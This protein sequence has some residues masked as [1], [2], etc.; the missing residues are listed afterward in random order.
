M[1]VLNQGDLLM[2]QQMQQ[3]LFTPSDDIM[4][5]RERE[6]AQRIRDNSDTFT[7]R[8]MASIHKMS[9]PFLRDFAQ[10]YGITFADGSR[11]KRLSSATIRREK[12]HTSTVVA[13]SVSR[14]PVTSLD[15]DK[16]TPDLLERARRRDQESVNG[17]IERLRE[18]A[19][20]H[21]REQAAKLVG[22][23]PTFMRR[24]AYDQELVFVGEST[25]AGRAN[26]PSAMRKL[27]GSLFRPGIK[28]KPSSALMMR[29]FVISDVAD[30]L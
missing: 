23:S 10:R 12:Q 4:A 24:L 25:N 30:V 29:H 27:Q 21:T 8:Q 15:A 14:K 28:V 9:I 17:F 2:Q 1:C 22:I 6:V 19:A 3:A 7:I 13:R 26:T 18:L 5:I 11:S 20:T 16:I